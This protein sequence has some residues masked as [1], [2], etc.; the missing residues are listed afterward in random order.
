[1]FNCITQALGTHFF[2]VGD[3]QI[4]AYVDIEFFIDGFLP[5]KIKVRLRPRVQK[6]EGSKIIT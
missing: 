1:M 2:G 3:I 4:M 6:Y 5:T